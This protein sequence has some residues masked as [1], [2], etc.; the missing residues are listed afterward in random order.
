MADKITPYLDALARLVDN[1][2]SCSQTRRRTDRPALTRHNASHSRTD[3]YRIAPGIPP[4]SPPVFL[5]ISPRYSAGICLTISC[6]DRP[7]LHPIVPGE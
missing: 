7:H 4:D 3:T 5:L 1:L 2:G 6:S